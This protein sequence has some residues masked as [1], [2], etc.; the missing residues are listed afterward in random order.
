MECMPLAQLGERA[1]VNLLRVAPLRAYSRLIR[2][3]SQTPVPRSLRGPVLGHLALRLGM[4]LSEAELELTEYSSLH[5]LFVRRL[6]PGLRPLEASLGGVTS[7]VDGC[8]S[9][10][11]RVDQGTLIQAKGVSYSLAQLLGDQQL[12]DELDGGTYVTLYLRPKD[13]HRIH[14][15][16]PG[17]ITGVRH[18]PGALF[19][20]KPY[21]VRH[22]K[23]LFVRNERLVLRLQAGEDAMAMVC[24]AAAGVGN[25]TVAFDSQRHTAGWREVAVPVAQGDEVAAFNLGS[26]VILVLPA[27]STMEPLQPGQEVRMGQTLANH[28]NPPAADAG[29]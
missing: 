11:G 23:G 8:V 9:A 17:V 13:Y 10:V 22:L 15:P 20:V 4:D 12:A 18:I 29:V 28:H 27:G 6:Q 24:V 16:L 14:A 1:L 26:T 5:A 2:V 19:P 7:P 25:I 3:L 21:M